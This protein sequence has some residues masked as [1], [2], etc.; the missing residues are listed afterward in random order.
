MILRRIEGVVQERLGHLPAVALL[1][2]RQVGKM[3][4]AHRV[5]AG[6]DSPYLDLESP[7]DREKLSDHQGC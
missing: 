5:A 3:T 1:G 6:R 4:L 7:R 2:T